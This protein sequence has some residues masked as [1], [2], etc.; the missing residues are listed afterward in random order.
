MKRKK[1]NNIELMIGSSLTVII[2]LLIYASFSWSSYTKLSEVK[3]IKKNIK[4]SG[5]SI[6]SEDEFYSQLEIL[7]GIELEEINLREVS[8]LLE[9]NP[10]VKAVRVSRQYPSTLSIEIVER[11]PVAILNIDPILML[12]R[13]G[14]VLPDQGKSHDFI[15]PCLSGFNPAKELY[16]AG[17]QTISVKVKETME[18]ITK[19]VDTYPSL[20]S[21]ISEVTL[22]ANDEYVIILADYPTKVILGNIDIWS[23]IEILG[24]FKNSLQNKRQL[25]DYTYLDLRYTNQ[26]IA[27]ERV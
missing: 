27:K 10:Y 5:N 6:V 21:N 11:E 24:K 4:I 17:H 1:K 25:S 13:E 9:S 15:I 7:E 14:V 2:M 22:N 19:I 26:V 23:K 12:D 20:Y 16:P 18:L 8:L 3:D